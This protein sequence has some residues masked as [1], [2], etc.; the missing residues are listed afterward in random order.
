MRFEA[1]LLL[2]LLVLFMFGGYVQSTSDWASSPMY[3]LGCA[4]GIESSRL[5]GLNR[6][7]RLLLGTLKE[8]N[9][10]SV[11]IYADQ[12]SKQAFLSSNST[13]YII[14]DDI[15]DH[16][17]ARTVRIAKCRNVLL[18]MVAQMVSLKKETVSDVHYIMMDLDGVND[19][20]YNMTIFNEVTKN[21]DKWQVL[22]FNRPNYYDLWALRYQRM[23]VNVWDTPDPGQ[24]IK[25]LQNDIKKELAHAEDPFY[26][27]FS[28]FNGIAIYQYNYT[29]GC[30][31]IGKEVGR[32]GTPFD[33]EH[34][35]FHKCMIAK[36]NATIVV[37]KHSLVLLSSAVK[38][39]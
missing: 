14:I 39:R 4:K 8:P 21:L 7:I 15:F 37:Y 25:V 34:V 3:I 38:R 11:I 31:Y 22:S 36:N 27:V 2:L 26:P 19:K 1:L 29:F 32:R 20:H 9:L 10:G 28:A 16:E 30:E 6:N 12:H 33:C 13:P 5:A 35:S 17:A 23:D 24:A 18:S